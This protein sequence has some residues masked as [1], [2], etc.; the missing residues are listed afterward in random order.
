[1]LT[2]SYLVDFHRQLLLISCHYFF[3]MHQI[4]CYKL[5]QVLVFF[6]YPY[7]FIVSKLFNLSLLAVKF[8]ANGKDSQVSAAFHST[9][10]CNL[11]SF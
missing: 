8:K 7:R 3:Q 1:M 11:L 10:T 9:P 6:L 2:R 4:F 5:F